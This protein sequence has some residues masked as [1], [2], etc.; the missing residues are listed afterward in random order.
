MRRI[1]PPGL[2]RMWR[3]LV[4]GHAAA[5]AIQA[6]RGDDQAALVPGA[7]A[8][9]APVPASSSASAL[10][11][12]APAVSEL[13]PR[14]LASRIRAAT[15]KSGN[16]KREAAKL[17]VK[18][19]KVSE[20]VSPSL[21]KGISQKVFGVA[22]REKASRHGEA[23]MS[24]KPGLRL[25]KDTSHAPR[26][27]AE[28]GAVSHVQA[29]GRRLAAVTEN[30]KSLIHMDCAD[31]AT[32]WCRAFKDKMEVTAQA[33]RA[34]RAAAKKKLKGQRGGGAR[35][36]AVP[37]MN[38]VQHARLRY[39]TGGGDR[40]HAALCIQIHSPTTPLPRA[41]YATIFNRK[42]KWNLVSGVTVG[43][44]LRPPGQDGDRLQDAVDRIPIIVK[45]GSNDAAAAND[46]V[47]AAEQR[48]LIQQ[49]QP[50][51]RWRCHL[52]VHCLGH[53]ACL[54][55][56]PAYERCGDLSSTI[57]RLG[58]VLQSARAARGFRAALERWAVTHFKYKRCL[59]LPVESATWRRDA[60]VALEGS[61]ACCDLSVEDEQLILNHDNGS[62]S[63]EDY[64]HYCTGSYAHPCPAGCCNKEE[65]LAI[66]KEILFLMHAGGVGE[67][68]LYRWKDMGK[69]WARTRRGRAQHDVLR[70]ALQ[71]LWDRKELDDAEAQIENAANVEDVPYPVRT[72]AKAK[73]VLRSF[74]NDPKGD[75][76]LK[77]SITTKP[78]HAFLNKVQTTDRLLEAYVTAM[79]VSPEAPS[80]KKIEGELC[81]KKLDFITGRNGCQ[82]IAAYFEMISDVSHEAWHTLS[83][84]TRLECAAQMV[85]PMARAWR[86]LVF[87]F[88]DPRFQLFGVCG[89]WGEDGTCEPYNERRTLELAAMVAAKKVDGCPGCLDAAFADN[90]VQYISKK[91]QEGV[92][93]MNDCA[94]WLRLSSAL[95]ERAHLLGQELKPK[96]S[97]GVAQDRLWLFALPR[98]R[99]SS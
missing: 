34:A 72:A 33:K 25:Q 53:Q 57:V 86:A 21:Q 40:G 16:W 17:K 76:L 84:A 41:N 83:E 12:P 7:P 18:V 15:R 28:R 32:M 24:L 20:L 54:L 88:E 4:G 99:V 69:A 68:L 78:P 13:D 37:C 85:T 29:V 56:K 35:N 27:L 94:A 38:V 71:T 67:P 3:A 44:R 51:Q 8:V 63:N 92:Q 58:H 26:R 52:D 75:L 93:V 42:R 82:V 31:D 64:E 48:A 59:V 49:R 98:A 45:L 10:A 91:P 50:N 60:A 47:T 6:G 97:R 80:V 89:P 95:V 9:A 22:S 96:R 1:A 70:G 61:V 65:S 73:S 62:W 19:A 43:E 5:D 23:L 74:A 66:C 90:M 87:V 77:G 11:V 79:Q 55:T 39:G 2:G 81:R 14:I 30:A 46:C 36:K